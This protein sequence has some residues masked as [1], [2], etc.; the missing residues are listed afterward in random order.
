VFKVRIRVFKLNREDRG[1]EVDLVVD[2]GASYPALPHSIVRELGIVAVETRNFR[3]ADGRIV[4][5]QLG[6][7]GLS[8]SGRS[9]PS[10]VVLGESDDAA[11]LGAIALESL[12][13]EADPVAKT[14]RP[15]T[16]Y[17]L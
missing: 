16:Q 1:R 3:L 5:R 8:Y 6:W 9:T 7:A 10:L 11:V 12:G 15:V 13:F 2:T 14:L 4:K 17:F